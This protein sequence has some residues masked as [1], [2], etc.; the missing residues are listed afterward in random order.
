MDLIPDSVPETRKSDY[1]ASRVSSVASSSGGTDFSPSVTYS[2]PPPSTR[3]AS[4]ESMRLTGKAAKLIG[5]IFDA[6]D[7]DGSG[8]LAEAEGKRFLLCSG[9]DEDNLDYCWNAVL[10]SDTDGDGEISKAEFTAYVLSGEDLDD[11]GAFV[12]RDHQEELE[13][14]LNELLA[15]NTAAQGSGK[16]RA[17]S[18]RL[19]S[20]L[21]KEALI[22]NRTG[23]D[24]PEILKEFF[25][26]RGGAE[27]ADEL[28]EPLAQLDPKVLQPLLLWQ[29]LHSRKIEAG[30]AS[31]SDGNGNSSSVAGA[32]LAERRTLLTGMVKL[33][34]RIDELERQLALAKREA[35]ERPRHPSMRQDVGHLAT[36]RA[37]EEELKTARHALEEMAAHCAEAE[38]KAAAL[39]GQVGELAERLRVTEAAAE[40]ERHEFAAAAKIQG[41]YAR[42][43]A[44]QD[45]QRI[46]SAH[47]QSLQ[48]AQDSGAQLADSHERCA[49]CI[50]TTT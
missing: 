21:A 14:E 15:Q 37:G 6:V 9:C 5:Q 20:G 42:Y 12:D 30:L 7:V 26:A 17:A 31:D 4:R 44:R 29:K 49:P 25:K 10:R 8:D 1:S 18:A 38:V 34:L 32:S 27:T 2:P 35:V 41:S 43:R 16:Q 40:A 11:A 36:L 22:V 39:D 3:E 45:M 23:A 13:R 33:R 48:K 28:Y 47:S 19:S 46:L 24:T 50:D